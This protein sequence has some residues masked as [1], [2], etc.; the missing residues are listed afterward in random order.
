MKIIVVDCGYVG[1]S[2]AAVLAVKN[3]VIVL[4]FL[5]SVSIWLTNRNAQ[6]LIRNLRIFCLRNLCV[7][8]KKRDLDAAVERADLF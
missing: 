8:H 7:F 4:I 6:L 1:I 5:K 2:N 3:E